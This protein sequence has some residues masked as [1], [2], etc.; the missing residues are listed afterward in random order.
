MA[1]SSSSYAETGS[2]SKARR[3]VCTT[4]RRSARDAE[5]IPSP[6]RFD[7]AEG[8]SLLSENPA[9]TCSTVD[10]RPALRLFQS[11]WDADGVTTAHLPTALAHDL[12]VARGWQIDGHAGHQWVAP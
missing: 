1:A 7:R 6:R 11:D 5:P 9:M 3:P 4:S 10:T 2:T 8:S 12:L